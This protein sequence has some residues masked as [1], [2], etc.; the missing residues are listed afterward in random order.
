MRQRPDPK[1]VVITG[2]MAAGKSTVAQRLAE[3][4]DRSVHVRGD[5]FRRMIVSGGAAIVPGRGEAMDAE[6]RL[7]YRL[8]A[9]VADEYARTGFTAVVQ[10]IILGAHLAEYVELVTSRPLAVVVL[11]PDPET[12]SRREAERPKSGYGDWT[13]ESLDNELREHTPRLGLWLDTSAQTADETVEEI[14]ARLP[15]AV[16]D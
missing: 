12:V 15:D 5:A 7:R 4:L 2:I 14:L 11:A 16:V 9:M 13:V 10:D 8:S 3:R 6:L 1:V